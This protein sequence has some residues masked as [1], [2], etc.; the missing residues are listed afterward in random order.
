MATQVRASETIQDLIVINNDR[1]EGYQ[2]AAKETKDSDLKDMFNSFSMQSNG[3]AAELRKF[4]PAGPDQPKRDETKNTGKLYRTW[5]DLRSAV[6]TN[7]R[8]AVL[9][10]CE[11]GEDTAKKHYEDALQNKEDL[12]SEAISLI[13]K[14]KEELKK[15]HDRVKALRDSAK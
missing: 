4:I 11:F 3:F 10:S 7:N 15:A 14:Q 1:Y 13:E 2:T 9:A 12:P 8:K 6:S 5:M